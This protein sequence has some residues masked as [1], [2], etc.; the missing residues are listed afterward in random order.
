LQQIVRGLYRP[1]L[2]FYINHQIKDAYRATVI[3]LVSLAA[4]LGFALLSPLVGVLLD[5]RGTVPAYCVMAAF[6]IGGV[7][8]F[9][10]LRRMQKVK[11]LRSEMQSE[12]D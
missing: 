1:T 7:G 10:L 2:R 9:I 12:I 11:K 5:G 4:S 3:S 8:F 6:S